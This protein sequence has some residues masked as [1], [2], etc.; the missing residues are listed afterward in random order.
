MLLLC[1]P[2]PDVW[3]ILQRANDHRRLF[4][5]QC[6][7]VVTDIERALHKKRFSAIAQIERAERFPINNDGYP[8]EAVPA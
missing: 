4:D 6:E 7:S 8:S 5:G 1:I 2:D 3:Q